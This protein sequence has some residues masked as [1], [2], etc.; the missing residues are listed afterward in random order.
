MQGGTEILSAG[1]S[2]IQKV[3]HGIHK[4]YSKGNKRPIKHMKNF[5]EAR[6]LV[7]NRSQEPKHLLAPWKGT[8]VTKP[9]KNSWQQDLG[10][11]EVGKP[12]VNQRM[13]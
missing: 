8:E 9:P 3:I 11:G 13:Q 6:P 7:N 12:Q 5:P 2:L 10:L 4:S 1:Q